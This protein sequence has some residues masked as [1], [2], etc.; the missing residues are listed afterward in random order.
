MSGT[1]YKIEDAT[2][3]EVNAFN[4]LSIKTQSADVAVGGCGRGTD[5]YEA[6]QAKIEALTAQIEA[7][8]TATAGTNG[9][10]GTVG[11]AGRIPRLLHNNFWLQI[12]VI[13]KN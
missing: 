13:L 12:K 6:L 10:N 7:L 4:P 5:G 1:H 2:E 11:T 9:T 3:K 8:K